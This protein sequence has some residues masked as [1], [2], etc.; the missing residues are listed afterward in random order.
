MR[1]AI[2]LPVIHVVLL[3]LLSVSLVAAQKDPVVRL[4][5]DLSEIPDEQ[6][7]PLLEMLGDAPYIGMSEGTHGMN[8]PLDFRNSLIKFLVRK[9]RIGVVTIESGL[10]E[11]RMVNDYIEG[12]DLDLDS[13]LAYGIKCTFGNFKQNRELLEW[14]REYN[15]HQSADERV[16][17]YGFDMSG[18]APNPFLEES[19]YALEQALDYLKK[20]DETSWNRFASELIP[21]SEYLHLGLPDDVSKKRFADLDEER[22]ERFVELINELVEEMRRQQF[23]YAAKT[24]ADDY[25]W[26]LRAAISARHNVLFLAN[27]VVPIIEASVREQAMLDNLS[28]IIGREQ[29]KG[30]LLFAHLAHL[31]KDVS[32]LNSDSVNVMVYNQFGE[33]LGEVLGDKYKVIGNFY[34]QLVYDDG[35][36]EVKDRSFPVWLGDSYPFRNFYVP[37]DRS[38]EMLNEPWIFG[39][40][41]SGGD[42]YMVP[43]KGVDIILYNE[44]QHF[45]LNETS[46]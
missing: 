23:S 3:L 20:V 35:V 46:E 12:K 31:S 43:S 44:K 28:W 18:C 10:L 21:L 30:I 27:T 2:G 7:E 14:L 8:E 6:L 22:R 5:E 15:A 41:S 33:Y 45:Y 19:S 4:P 16:H 42:V 29:N 40:P 11:S 36:E 1:K 38:D 37:V 32:V 34:Y 26:A 25:A 17:F 39:V 24:S 9:Q 13:V